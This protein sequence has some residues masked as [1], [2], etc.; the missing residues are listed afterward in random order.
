M[1]IRRKQR[2]RLIEAALDLTPLIDVVFL[3]VIFLLISTTFKKRQL[4]IE[5]NLPKAGASQGR[6][7]AREHQIRI[8]KTGAMYLCPNEEV[9]DV[10]QAL[11]CSEPANKE[12]LGKQFTALRKA[13]E[14]VLLGIYA[15]ADVP[16]R[17]VADVIAAAEEANLDVNLHYGSMSE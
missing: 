12:D 10:T 6:V 9:T 5:L 4:V 14:G 17:F 8:D 16:Y 11:G 15:D 7:E 3:L 13:F 2:S 1:S